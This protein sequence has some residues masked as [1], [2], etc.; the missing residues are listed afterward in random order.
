[1]SAADTCTGLPGF[2]H[3]PV[4]CSCGDEFGA[5]LLSELVGD[6]GMHGVLL[7]TCS[8]RNGSLV[9]SADTHIR[10]DHGS[11]HGIEHAHRS[12]FRPQA[13]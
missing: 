6:V 2:V 11:H 3:Q 4:M 13:E 8:A 5:T 9:A 7:K 10:A 1:V 12:G